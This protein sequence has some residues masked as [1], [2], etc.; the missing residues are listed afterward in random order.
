M[1]VEPK[2]ALGKKA[3]L[4]IPSVA[5]PSSCFFC[6]ILPLGANLGKEEEEKTMMGRWKIFLVLF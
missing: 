5:L 1:G 3:T 2:S 6:S 4:P